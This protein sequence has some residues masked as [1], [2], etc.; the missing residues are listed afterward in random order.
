MVQHKFT[1]DLTWSEGRNGTGN[2]QASNLQTQIS[3]PREMNGPGIGTNP[4]EM[5][6]GRYNLLFNYTSRFIRKVRNRCT[7]IIH[8]GPWIC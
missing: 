4:D 6:L 7:G 8:A 3:I 1:M 5:L 2:I